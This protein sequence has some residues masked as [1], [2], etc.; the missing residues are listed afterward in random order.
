MHAMV[1]E[2]EAGHASHQRFAE[3]VRTSLV[4]SKRMLSDLEIADFKAVAS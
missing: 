1:F 2:Q 3:I 4:S